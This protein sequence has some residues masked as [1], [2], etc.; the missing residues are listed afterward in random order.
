MID[1]QKIIE[2]ILVIIQIIILMGLFRIY[3]NNYRKVKIGFAIG[4]LLFT[5]I[6]IIGN[7]F[8][9]ISLFTS[10]SFLPIVEN[11]IELIGIGLLY[12]ISRRY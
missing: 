2:I 11:L 9:L 8:A 12:Y 4:L 6:L 1:A 10:E 3:Y 7:V 5:V